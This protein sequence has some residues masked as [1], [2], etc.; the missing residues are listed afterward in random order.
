M[1]SPGRTTGGVTSAY[2]VRD[3]LHLLH[4]LSSS[5][6]SGSYKCHAGE[7]SFWRESRRDDFTGPC[8]TFPSSPGRVCC[9]FPAS[10]RRQKRAFPFAFLFPCLFRFVFVLFRARACKNIARLGFKK[11]EMFSSRFAAE[12]LIR[13]NAICALE[14]VSFCYLILL[15]FNSEDFFEKFFPFRNI[16]IT[17]IRN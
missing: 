5:S 16:S 15:V 7:F 10:L 17:M 13:R 11:R 9:L 14:R 8:A 12:V 6:S 2:V 1:N 3:P 4:R